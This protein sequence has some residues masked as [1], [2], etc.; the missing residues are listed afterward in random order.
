MKKYGFLTMLCAAI[1]LFSAPVMANQVILQHVPAYDWYNGCG[2][3]A[4]GMILGYW[5]LNGYDNLLDASGWDAVKLTDNVKDQISSPEHNAKYNPTPDDASLADPPKTSIADF[6]NTSVGSLG[7]GY[8]YVSD[9]ANVFTDYAAY[10]GYQFDA[11]YKDFSTF[12]WSDYV[13]E[14][15][16]GRPMMLAVDNNQS[17]QVNHFVTAIGYEDRGSEGVWY[18]AY[19]TWSESEDAIRWEPFRGLS[20][21]WDWGIGY[22]TF[23][24]P[25]SA[26][27]KTTRSVA[28]TTPVITTTPSPVIPTTPTTPATTP[29]PAT[30]LLLASGVAALAAYKKFKS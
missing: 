26:T 11:S 20:S 18:A 3:T 10:R 30:M 24:D 9:S 23:V 29:E 17:G 19:D 2:P 12:S 21:S 5:D 13:S 1:F 15:D 22:A 27:D 14:I 7:Y 25:V 6:F 8:S 4:A 28:T 16:A